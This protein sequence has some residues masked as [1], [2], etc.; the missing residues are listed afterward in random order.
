[1][2][3]SEPRL[4]ADANSSALPKLWAAARSEFRARREA[5]AGRKRLERELAAYTTQ[6]DLDDLYAILDN[7]D[8]ADTAVVRDILTRQ[9]W[10]RAA[11]WPPAPNPAEAPPTTKWSW[12]LA[13]QPASRSGNR[14][15][16]DEDGVGDGSAEDDLIAEASRNSGSPRVDASP[17]VDLDL[18]VVVLRRDRGDD[19]GAA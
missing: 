2:H 17:P 14:A 12:A 3:A 1:M 19:D 16:A 9:Q 11:A 6:A 5:R 4:P 10:Q 18:G 15:D 13:S 8:D 7:H